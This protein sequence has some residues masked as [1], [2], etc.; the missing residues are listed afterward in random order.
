[1]ICLHCVLK[2]THY[3]CNEIYLLL[4]RA[5]YFKVLRSNKK[6]LQLYVKKCKRIFRVKVHILDLIDYSNVLDSFIF[7]VM[8][9]QYVRVLQYL[10]VTVPVY[11]AL[12]KVLY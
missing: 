6:T 3:V 2:V 5:S 1:M 10:L 11:E 8:T 9:S 12:K 4:R 7:D